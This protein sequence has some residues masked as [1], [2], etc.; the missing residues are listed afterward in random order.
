MLDNDTGAWYPSAEG[1]GSTQG[2]GDRVYAG[3][4]TATSGMREYLQGG[5]LS[6]GSNAGSCYL[7]CGSGLG[8][9]NWN[10]LSRSYKKQ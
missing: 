7:I 1:S 4:A 5:G 2:T 6:S 9:T 8:T 3:G 10:F